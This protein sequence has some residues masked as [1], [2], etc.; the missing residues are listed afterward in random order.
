MSLPC[1]R[2][3]DNDDA[4]DNDKYGQ[5]D[6]KVKR[7]QIIIMVE[8]FKNNLCL[9]LRYS[10]NYYYEYFFCLTNVAQFFYNF[11][12]NSMWAEHNLRFVNFVYLLIVIITII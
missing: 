3:D 7:K 5:N 8:H 11:Q 2:T 10:C 1:L 6:E 9:L 12:F 4:G